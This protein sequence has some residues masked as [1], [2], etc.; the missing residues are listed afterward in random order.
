MRGENY[1]KW[2][3]LIFFLALIVGLCML[4]DKISEIIDN[5]AS[6]RKNKG[7]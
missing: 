6:K 7:R 4:Q 5:R 1:M 2:L 3:A